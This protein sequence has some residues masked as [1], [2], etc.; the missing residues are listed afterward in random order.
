M[1]SDAQTNMRESMLG[2]RLHVCKARDTQT[3]NYSNNVRYDVVHY[4]QTNH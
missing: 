1:V 3:I 4:D 2:Q